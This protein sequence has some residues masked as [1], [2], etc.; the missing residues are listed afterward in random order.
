[1][2]V[3]PR[4]FV[5]LTDMAAWISS[6]PIRTAFRRMVRKIGRMKYGPING[7]L[8]ATVRTGPLDVAQN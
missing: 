3:K 1:M 4:R 7:T 6:L 2:S 5:R 8:Q